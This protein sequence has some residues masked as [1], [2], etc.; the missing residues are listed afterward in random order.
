MADLDK[1]TYKGT[2]ATGFADNT[3]QAIIASIM[4]QFK[5]DTADSFTQTKYASPS[6]AG[7]TIT[8]DF[9]DRQRG[10]FVFA[11]ISKAK[12]VAFSNA[13]TAKEL[14]ISATV[15]DLAGTLEFDASV[16][17]TDVRYETGELVLSQEGKVLIHAINDGTNWLAEVSPEYIIT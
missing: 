8:C 4:R 3:T 10:V 15:S 11:A 13:S 9:G 6:V 2:Y 5:D 16:L 7:G 14:W 1:N 12:V 17:F